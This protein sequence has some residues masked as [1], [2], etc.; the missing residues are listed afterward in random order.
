MS[1]IPPVTN[2]A[3]S[4]ANAA[5]ASK[6]T[7]TEKDFLNLL[8]TQMTSQD[9]L[10]PQS[11]TEFAA[12]LAQFS[13]LSESQTMESDMASLQANSLIG[14]T[15]DVTNVD[16]SVTEGTVSGVSIDKGVPQL[17]VNG[18]LYTMNQLAA[19]LP[20]PATT[21]TS[22]SGSTPTAVQPTSGSAPTYQNVISN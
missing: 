4:A 21:P 19:I 11:G 15:V 13:A 1:T 3:N 12:Q 14:H 6:Q 22:N 17:V 9:P 8:V 16:N 18:Q 5:L 20:M 2:N 7:L 10:N